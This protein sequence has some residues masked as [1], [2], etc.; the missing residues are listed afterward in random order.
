MTLDD[1]TLLLDR[2]EAEAAEAERLRELVLSL[3][4]RVAAPSEVLSRRAE[5]DCPGCRRLRVEVNR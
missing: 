4:G 3:A 2:L 5:A 1:V